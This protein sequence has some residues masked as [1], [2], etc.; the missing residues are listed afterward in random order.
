[1][2]AY[3]D[4]WKEVEDVLTRLPLH[5]QPSDQQ[6]KVGD[7][8][9][10]PKG[11]NKFISQELVKK[12][13]KAGFK[14][15]A[16]F[17]FL[18]KDL[19]FGK[20]HTAIEVQFSNYPFLFNNVMRMEFFHKHGYPLFGKQLQLG[21]IITKSGKIP[22]SNSTLYYEQAEKL[23]VQLTK[24]KLFHIPFRLVG[25][26]PDESE[27]AEIYWTAYGE[28]YKRTGQGEKRLCRVTGRDKL[29]YQLLDT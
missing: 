27:M 13:W 7:P 11:T 26:F 25:L 19:D 22:A 3:N 20:D 29:S 16:E 8:I 5:M 4:Q 10:D 12:Y 1:M 15:P 24:Y 23:L 18:G 6:G 28:R 2:D 9:F 21:M 14:L 17:D